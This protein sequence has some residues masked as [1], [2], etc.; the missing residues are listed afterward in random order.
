MA[1]V[2]PFHH[3]CAMKQVW[4][5]DFDGTITRCDS[6]LAFIRFACGNCRFIGGFLLYSPLLVLMKL[7]LYPNWKV[8]QKVFSHFFQGKSIADFDALCRSFVEESPS[9]IRPE[10]LRKMDEGRQQGAQV[11]IV[12][13][14]ID[15][16]VQPFFPSVTVLGTRIEVVEGR[17]TG[18]F[19]TKNCYGAEKVNRLREM[20]VA[21]REEYYIVAFGDS[22][23]DKELLAY[24]DKGYFKPFG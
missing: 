8:K 3:L 4:V 9:L 24:A 20:L 1:R 7:R 15:N 16:W 18:R 23:G 14:S 10:A 22:R 2:L 21:P 19:L 5:F 13:A 11:M 12:S 17:L 6:L